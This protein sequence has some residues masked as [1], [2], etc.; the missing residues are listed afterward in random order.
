MILLLLLLLSLSSY[1]L[2]GFY[3]VEKVV[4][5]HVTY[6][7]IYLRYATLSNKNAR[8]LAERIKHSNLNSHSLTS[9]RL[10]LHHEPFEQ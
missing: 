8:F 7:G 9:H 5:K 2:F 10:V 4:I 3:K 6:G 1:L